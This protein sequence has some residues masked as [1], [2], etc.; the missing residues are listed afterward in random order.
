MLSHVINYT[1]DVLMCMKNIKVRFFQNR[2]IRIVVIV[3]LS[4]G[5][6]G[7]GTAFLWH[8]LSDFLTDIKQARRERT[9][10]EIP[11]L[12]FDYPML[13]TDKSALFSDGY[14]DKFDYSHYAKNGILVI[15]LY[16]ENHVYRTGQMS[17]SVTLGKPVIIQPTTEKTFGEVLKEIDP[18]MLEAER[19]IFFV[20]NCPPVSYGAYFPEHCEEEI[21]TNRIVQL[22]CV[23]PISEQ[24]SKKL[25][26]EIYRILSHN[27]SIALRDGEYIARYEEA[28][29]SNQFLFFQGVGWPKKCVEQLCENVG[30]E[31]R[32]V[33]YVCPAMFRWGLSGHGDRVIINYT[34]AELQILKKKLQITEN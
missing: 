20:E 16:Y 22:L 28:I 26:A 15:P 17:R 8:C 1:A 3:L 9:E 31:P 24:E 14:R 25:N 32:Y 21:G 6:L 23:Y 7:I 11:R 34:A 27:D 18:R 4:V 10:R 2:Y 29:E 12:L 19:F 30:Y 13:V 5:Y 33:D